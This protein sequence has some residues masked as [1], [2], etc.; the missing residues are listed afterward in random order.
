MDIRKISF[1]EAASPGANIFSKNWFPRLGAVLLSTILKERGYE[2]KAFIEDIA[3]P[4]WSYVENSDVVCISTITCTAPRAY[5]IADRVRQKGI[6]VV[7]GGPHTSFL[8]EEALEHAD[9]VVRGE[10]DVTL[11]ELINY[12]EK[13]I[14]KITSIAGLSYR[15]R[16]GSVMNNPPRPLIENL[17]VLPEP[18]FELVYNWQPSRTYPISASRGCPFNCRFCCVIQMFGRKYR[19]KSVEATLR[20][21]KHVHS[22]SKASKFFVDDNF[23]A[24][25]R[26]TKE[27]LRA[28]IAEGITS[29]WS[30]QVRVDVAEDRELMRLMADSGCDTL[31]IGFESVN[32]ETLEAYNKKQD[33]DE[34]VNCIKTVRDHGIEIHGMFV[35]GADTDTVDTIKETADFSINLGIDTIQFLILTPAPGTPLFYEMKESGRLLHTDW[36]KYD[37]HHVVHK[38][39]LMEPQTLHIGSLKAMGQFYSWKYI[40]RHFA[41][42]DFFHAAVGLYGKKAIKDALEEAMDYLNSITRLIDSPLPEQA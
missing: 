34:I 25:R 26:Q 4:D 18:D 6:P 36:S 1:I 19:F 16:D 30:A 37:G 28:L 13:G 42:L 24:N 20:E 23:A 27:L 14:P 39:L 21:L 2:V 5:K 3:D 12:L 8:P 31:H 9:Y 29:K 38:P 17:D 11:P 40:F 10:G 15:D 35:L 7:I 33:I 32:P 22:I 41:H